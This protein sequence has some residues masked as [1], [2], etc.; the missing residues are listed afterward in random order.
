MTLPDILP[1]LAFAVTVIVGLLAVIAYCLRGVMRQMDEEK[2][3]LPMNT[4]GR[5]I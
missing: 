1:I 4:K 2:A 3:G 5:V